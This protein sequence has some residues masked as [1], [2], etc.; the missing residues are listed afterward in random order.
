[1][2]APGRVAI[3]TG[4]ASYIGMATA[5]RLASRGRVFLADVIEPEDIPE[6]GLFVRTD[7]TSE[8]DLDALVEAA[9][10]PTGS[11]DVCVHAAAIFDDE[12]FSS[13]WELWRRALDVNL[14]SAAVLTGKVAPHMPPGSSVVYVSSV[15]GKQSQPN[16]LVYSVTKTALLALARNGSQQLAPQG[17]R[18]NTV[19]PGWTWSRNLERRYGSR[20][21]ADA[22]GAEWHPL[23]RMADPDEVASAVA[24]LVSDDAAFVTGADLAVDGGYSAMGPEAYGAAFE[25]HPTV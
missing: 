3:V 14:V 15:S 6:G 22:L 19:S 5:A 8:A 9:I 23:G 12:G 1:M 4:G 10:E 11:I 21:R 18:V 24:F 20:E 2:S 17:I 7:L 25:K 13:P 16:R